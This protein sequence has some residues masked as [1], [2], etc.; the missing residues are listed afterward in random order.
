MTIDMDNPIVRKRRD[1]VIIVV[2]SPEKIR[3]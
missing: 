1:Q 2:D 3:G